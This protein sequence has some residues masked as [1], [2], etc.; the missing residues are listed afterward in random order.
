MLKILILVPDKNLKLP[1]YAY[2]ED[3]DYD[4]YVVFGKE[5]EKTLENN[6]KL[7]ETKKALIDEVLKEDYKF[8]YPEKTFNSDK[9]E[10][11]LFTVEVYDLKKEKASLYS[12][13]LIENG[14]P[15]TDPFIQS[16]GKEKTKK[17]FKEVLFGV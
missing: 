7:D 1:V 10:I 12:N 11:K 14:G 2:S 8:S 5:P 13:G 4:F 16:F 15:A 9:S 3:R 6:H 17:F